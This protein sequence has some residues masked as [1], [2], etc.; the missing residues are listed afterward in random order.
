M[1]DIFIICFFF[2]SLFVCV[3]VQSH[4][5]DRNLSTVLAQ[6][7][8]TETT[9]GSLCLTKLQLMLWRR[10][11]AKS[12]PWTLAVSFPPRQAHHPPDS[13]TDHYPCNLPSSKARCQL[14]TV[15]D[16]SGS[17]VLGTWGWAVLLSF[18]LCD[19][20]DQL[21]NRKPEIREILGQKQ[22]LFLSMFL[23]LALFFFILHLFLS[24]VA[25]RRGRK[26]HCFQ[27]LTFLIFHVLRATTAPC[28]WA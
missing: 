14:L 20:I 15:C 19:R 3:Y 25:G 11:Q 4:T 7:T 12:M 10:L 21:L 23:S 18:L 6:T 5:S 24:S 8:R 28:P 27:V 2:L 16:V 17:V 26:S 22:N 1:H 9:V 13:S